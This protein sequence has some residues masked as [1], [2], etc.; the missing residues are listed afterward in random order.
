MEI[1][2]SKLLD[3]RSKSGLLK[4]YSGAG[5]GVCLSTFSSGP[6]FGEEQRGL[7]PPKCA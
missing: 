6:R 2:V 7:K 5:A 1:C 4:Q 3:Q